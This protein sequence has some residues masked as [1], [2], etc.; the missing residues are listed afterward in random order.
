MTADSENALHISGER[1]THGNGRATINVS[2]LRRQR[3][4]YKAEEAACVTGI[5]RK[6]QEY[7]QNPYE[8]VCMAWMISKDT[9][10][11]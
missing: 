10:K 4:I 6:I 5:S 7:S 2:T 1:V 9:V 8:Y 11:Q 3:E